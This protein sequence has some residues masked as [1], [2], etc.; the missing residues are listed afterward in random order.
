MSVIFRHGAIG[1]AGEN[2]VHIQIKQRDAPLNGVDAQ[3]I[4]RRVDIHRAR[5]QLWVLLNAAVEQVDH[6]L[7]FQLIA[8]HTGDNA[9]AFSAV[10][11]GQR[12]EPVLFQL[13]LF[14]YCKRKACDGFF[15][16]SYTLLSKKPF[17]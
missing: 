16:G 4:D 8:V 7:P 1:I 12:G 6:I 2:A 17:S 10:V 3:R 14:V 13:Q 15:H 9:D 5:Q 11:A